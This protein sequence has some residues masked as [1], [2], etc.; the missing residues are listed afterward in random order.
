V[1]DTSRLAV[2]FKGTL[3]KATLDGLALAALT[4]VP[5]T[6]YGIAIQLPPATGHSNTFV[7]PL[8]LVRLIG[9]NRSFT[10]Q[11]PGPA[12][13][14]PV[15]QVSKSNAN[16]ALIP[17]PEAISV[18]YPASA[19]IEMSRVAVVFN[20]TF[21][22]G[23]LDGLALAVLIPVPET[24]YG[25]PMQVPPAIG[26]SNTFVVPLEAVNAVGVNRSLTLQVPGPENP[27]PVPQ[28]S[29]SNANGALIPDPDATSVR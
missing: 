4:P 9:V 8:E 15:P 7:V 16:G 11:V 5:E 3:P 21:P 18:R 23:T 28:V 20:A 26:H 10:L 17:E 2:V 6:E 25:I 14:P 12:K 19:V 24:E 22:N 13:P 1:I 29:K 27:P